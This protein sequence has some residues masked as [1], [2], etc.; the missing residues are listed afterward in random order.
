[1]K[2]GSRA[3]ALAVF[4]ALAVPAAGHAATKTVQVGPF[5]GAQMKFQD[6]SGD[7]NA[8]FRRTITI[9]KG[10]K[11]KWKFNGFHSVT[12]VPGGEEDPGLVVPDASAPV[13]GAADANGDPFWFN[14]L[15]SLAINPL[16]AFPQGGG[17]Y[18]S[19]K[20]R[21]SGLP[22]GDGPPPAYKLKFNKTGTFQ[23][24]CTVHPGMAA[25]VKVLSKNAHVPSKSKDEK[26]AKK[27]QKQL[28]KQVRNRTTGSNFGSLSKTMVA[29]NDKGNGATIFKFFPA[30][31]VFKVGDTVR[32]RM[33][34][35]T[36]E[37]HTFSIG[38]TNGQNLYLDN[39]A[40]NLLGPTGLDPIGGYPSDPPPNPPSFTAASHGNGFYNSGVLDR[41]GAT[42]QPSSAQVTFSQPGTYHMICLIHPF[43][44]ATITVNL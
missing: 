34:D 33:S 3:L 18:S 26:A 10:D 41:D 8:Y 17:K 12:F 5:G 4:G 11:V 24:I 43:M 6:A 20:L 29:G 40:A 2:R 21:S 38:P 15:P 25:K 28:L 9:N 1:M 37:A 14:G 19:T 22:L 35:D 39:L 7:A 16:A 23:Y 27:E 32:L 36:T 44:T 31:P 13:N 42:P 30:N